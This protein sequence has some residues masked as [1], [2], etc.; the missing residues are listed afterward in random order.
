MSKIIIPY[1]NPLKFHKLEPDEE[2]QYLTKHMEEWNFRNTV[3]SYQ[4]IPFYAQPF[5]N[6]DEG[7]QVVELINCKERVFLTPTVTQGAESADEAGLFLYEI[8][9]PLTGV[10][11][12]Y[13]YLRITA[14]ALVMV[15]E[16]IHIKETHNYSIKLEYSNYK[17]KDG[18]IFQSG[19]EL[20]MRVGG[21]IKYKAPASRDTFYEDQ[22]LDPTT[23]DSVPYRIHELY[24]GGTTGIPD[25]LVDRINRVLGCSSFTV[26]GKSFT[27]SDG[28]KLEEKSAD[29]YSLRGWAVDLQESENPF[30]AEYT[31]DSPSEEPSTT[32]LDTPVLTLNVDSDTEITVTWPAV[33]NAD[34]YTILLATVDSFAFA[35]VNY[36]G[37]NLTYTF[38]GLKAGKTYWVWGRAEGSGSYTPSLYDKESAT[39]DSAPATPV[40]LSAPTP[41]TLVADSESQI[42]A[43]WTAVVNATNY[44]FYLS[45]TPA[46]ADATEHY[47]GLLTTKTVTGLLADTTY[48]GW[49]IA[50]GDDVSYLD[51][52]YATANTTTD[53]FNPATVT[54]DTILTNPGLVGGYQDEDEGIHGFF[55]LGDNKEFHFNAIS[56]TS[57]VSIRLGIKVS[58]AAGAVIDFPSDYVG[59]Y[60]KYIHQDLTEH[61]S[62]FPSSQTTIDF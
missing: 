45:P 36:S 59:E 20:Q 24:V 10:D 7:D 54:F 50:E 19:I 5:Q 42:T 6:F 40:T 3:P 53:A 18:L 61:I 8:D 35:T 22:S 56:P 58:G 23:L 38:T 13:Y 30:S 43:T 46:F 48:Y 29:D 11:D 12:G 27:K 51:S 9:E 37:T 47:S 41:F 57:G 15:S 49:A 21:H 60:F 44:K 2:A 4:T 16:P 1:L 52:A 28:A 26:D 14:G 25:Y 34:S 55:G 39:T 17:D 32:Q 31:T 33:A 62:T